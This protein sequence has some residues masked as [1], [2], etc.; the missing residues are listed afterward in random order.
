MP[1]PLPA[2]P[3]AEERS[4]L[5]AMLLST[6]AARALAW[7]HWFNGI[8][9]LEHACCQHAG[10]A[11]SIPCHWSSCET[12][13]VGE[14]LERHRNSLFRPEAEVQQPHLPPDPFS[15]SRA[16]SNKRRRKMESG[17]GIRPCLEI[18]ADDVTAFA[19]RHSR[20]ECAMQPSALVSRT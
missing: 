16:H 8:C 20:C 4:Q 12:I 17:S 13:L 9:N 15:A 11:P 14:L 1:F 7:F 6:N 19:K 18:S 10:S 3:L 2:S 5:P